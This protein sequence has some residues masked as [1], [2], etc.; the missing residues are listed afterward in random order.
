MK[1]RV[2]DLAGMLHQF[3]PLLLFSSLF[4]SGIQ[5][6]LLEEQQLFSI[7]GNESH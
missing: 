7:Y 2:C 6:R 3:Y 4:L 1:G 5:T